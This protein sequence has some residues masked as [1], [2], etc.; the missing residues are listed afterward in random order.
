LLLYVG[1]TGSLEIGHVFKR[2]IL[3]VRMIFC[4]MLV[5]GRIVPGGHSEVDYN[6]CGAD[7]EDGAV[8]AGETGKIKAIAVAGRCK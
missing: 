7:D 4:S 8:P 6:W 2:K 3:R 1:L 5:L